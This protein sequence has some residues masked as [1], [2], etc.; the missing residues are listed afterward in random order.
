MLHKSKFQSASSILDYIW[1]EK[2][3]CEDY[4][5]YESVSE[6]FEEVSLDWKTASLEINPEPFEFTQKTH[7]PKPVYAPTNPNECSICYEE[8]DMITVQGCGHQFCAFCILNHV[9]CKVSEGI[10]LRHQV[11]KFNF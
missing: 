7:K 5:S 4:E 2:A 6:S 9:D 8:C 3:D 1:T 10:N 11:C